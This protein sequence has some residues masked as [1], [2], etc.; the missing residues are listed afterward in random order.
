MIKKSYKKK[1]HELTKKYFLVT[2]GA[3]LASIGL[4]LFLIPNHVIDGGVVGISIML[5]HITDISLSMFLVLLNIPFA[6]LGWKQI[7]FKF[8]VCGS[9]SIILLAIFSEIVAHNFQPI[10]TDAFLASIFG[11]IIDGLGVGLIIKAGGFLDGT[12]VV[13]IIMD[14]KSVFSVG[15]VEMFIN[16]FILSS[17]G[18]LFGWDKAMYS[19]FA[20]YIIS[21]SID[22]AVKGLN[23]AY[24]VMII[25][26]EYE[27]VK[28][29]LLEKMNRGVTVIYGEGGYS[30]QETRI[31]Y[32]IVTRF[33]IDEMK[34]IISDI[35]DKAFITINSV[36]DVIGGKFSNNKSTH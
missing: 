29:A 4:E 36:N 9:I 1:A 19:L 22:V 23:E 10:T 33:E 28:S 7:G 14:R 25:T 34:G 20:Y 35:D 5:E 11:G 12:N 30:G 24:T 16:F 27:E 32:T 6:I 26:N 2:I 31:L 13:S 3:I 17:A 18:F 15:E 8:S 21:K